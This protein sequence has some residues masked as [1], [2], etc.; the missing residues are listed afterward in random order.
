MEKQIQPSEQKIQDL[1]AALEVRP[2]D[3]Q[4]FDSL[5]SLYTE[6]A[7]W[8][9]LL[10][11]Y[12]R[13]ARRITDGPA[14]AEVYYEMGKVW[15]ERVGN[16]QQAMRH[17]QLAYRA[18]PTYT[19]ALSAAR[20]IYRDLGNW[21][22]VSRLLEIQI[23]VEEDPRVRADLLCGLGQALQNE[24]GDARRA[25]EC[26]EKALE[27]VP[28]HPIARDAL[29]A[30]TASREKWREVADRMRDEAE[31]ATEPA[32]RAS[33]Y[34]RIAELYHREDRGA[35][36]V[37]SY[38]RRALE[39]D[40]ANARAA[41]ILAQVLEEQGRLDELGRFLAGRAAAAQSSSERA[42]I[43]SRLAQLAQTTGN[44]EAALA[45]WREVLEIDPQNAEA[46]MAL[47]A[48]LRRR[49]AHPE[50]FE[51]ADRAL[52]TGLSQDL[53]A[54]LLREVGEVAWRE[55]GDRPRAERYLGSLRRIAPSDPLCLEFFR[56]EMTEGQDW[57]GQY[58][59]LARSVRYEPDVS[60]RREIYRTMARMAEERLGNAKDAIDAWRSVLD[61]DRGDSEA[62]E[63][64]K[65]LYRRA[66]RWH[67]LVELLKGESEQL[68]PER[69]EEKIALYEEMADIYGRRLQMEPMVVNTL[70]A[71]LQ[72]APTHR[73]TLDRLAAIYERR[74]SW[75]QLAE[76]LT[77][78]AS[79]VD[80]PSD[81]L[82]L[83]HR[84]AEIWLSR[85]QSPEDA[86]RRYEE[87][88]ALNP[89]DVKALQSLRKI[90]EQRRA[91]EPLVQIYLREID[92]IAD[93]GARVRR[94]REVAEWA[95]KHLHRPARLIELWNKVLEF[96]DRD[97]RAL[98]ALAVLY[99]REERW[100][101]LAE[102]L[103]RQIQQTEDAR[104]RVPLMKRLGQLW[105]ERLGREDHALALW[106]EALALD[107]DNL[108]VFKILRDR[109]LKSRDYAA[110]E[111]LYARR[112]KWEE[113]VD[114]L[115]V[116]A[117][118]HPDPAQKCNIYFQIADVW[119]TRLARKDRS[120]RVYE[121][122]LELDP[123]NVRA[124]E[125]LRTGYEAT[126]EWRKLA[127]VE[128]VLAEATPDPRERAD[129]L[130][131]IGQIYEE[132]LRRTD[133]AFTHAARAF[134]DAPSGAEAIAHLERLAEALG[135]WK[136]LAATF[137]EARQRTEDPALRLDLGLRTAR[138]QDQKLG[139]LEEALAAWEAVRAD[140][141][142]HVEALEALARLYRK[143]ERWEK[144]LELL[145]AELAA[146]EEPAR[147]RELLYEIAVLEEERLDRPDEAIEVYKAI[148]LVTDDDPQALS[149][150]ARLYEATERHEPLA[151]VLAR[152]LDRARGEVE[153]VPLLYRLGR[154]LMGPLGDPS[155]AVERFRRL[156]EI[157]PGHDGA[158]GALE[159][160][161]RDSP[162]RDAAA[163]LLAQVHRAQGAWARALDAYE[164]LVRAAAPGPE[165]VDLLLEM[166]RICEQE[167]HSV[168]EA[169]G[170]YARA[171]H[172]DPADPRTFAELD[173]VA[174]LLDRD[175]ALARLLASELKRIDNTGYRAQLTL[176]AAILHEE[177][178]QAA[179]A[180]RYY[181]EALA[182]GLPDEGA[183]RALRSLAQLH[184]SRQD[185]ASLLATLRRSLDFA[186]SSAQRR[187]ILVR[188]GELL[189]GPLG[190]APRAI[191]AYRNALALDPE[192]EEVLARLAALYEAGGDW[193]RLAD[194]L[195]SQIRLSRAAAE[196][197]QLHCRLG[198]LFANRLD[199]PSDA[200]LEL[201]AALDAD[202]DCAAAVDAIEA[203]VERD[204]DLRI[205]AAETLAP[206]YESRGDMEKVSLALEA[207]LPAR[208]PAERVEILHRLAAIA[209]EAGKLERAFEANLR[210]LR[211]MPADRET[212]VRLGRLADALRR[213]PDLLETLEAEL[214]RIEDPA[215]RAAAL[216]DMASAAEERL[217]D[218]E[219]SAGY[220]E[221][222][223]EI[224]PESTAALDGLEELYPRVQRWRELADLLDRRLSAASDPLTAREI[225]VRL[226]QILE[227]QLQD[228]ARAID[229][230]RKASELF[231]EDLELLDALERLHLATGQHEELAGVYLKRADLAASAEQ[232]K[233]Y[234]FAAAAL[235]EEKLRHPE[236]AVQIYRRVADADPRDLVALR[237][238]VRLYEELG[239]AESLL[240]SLTLLVEAIPEG[241]DRLSLR[242]RIGTLWE[243]PLASPEQAVEIY[244]DLLADEPEH[245]PTIASLEAMLETPSRL[246]A[247]RVLGPLYA[248]HGEW[249]KLV[250]ALEV[251]LSEVEDAEEKVAILGR[252]AEVRERRL[253]D[254]EGAF[255]AHRQALRLSPQTETTITELERIASEHDRYFELAAAYEEILPDLA[256]PVLARR[257]SLKV[258]RI[259]DDIL[260][261]APRAVEKYK[262]VL[263][264]APEE[265]SALQALERLHGE[266]R[267]WP[268]LAHTLRRELELAR[269]PQEQVEL[270]HRL[271]SLFAGALA[272]PVQAVQSFASA[273]EGDPDHAGTLRALESMLA[274]GTEVPAVAALL[275]PVY[276]RHGAWEKLARLLEVEADAIPAPSERKRVY[277][278]IAEIH[279]ERLHNLD[280]AFAFLARAMREDPA[281]TETMRELWRLSDITGAWE[282]LAALLD[283]EQEREELGDEVRERLALQVAAIYEQHLK[284]PAAAAERYQSVVERNPRCTAALRQLDR[285][286]TTAE[287][288]EPLARVLRLEA[289]AAHGSEEVG[290]LARLA[291]LYETRLGDLD[292]AVAISRQILEKD[293]RNLTALEALER[294]FRERDEPEELFRVYERRA[295]LCAE[296]TERA[297]FFAAM[298][299]LA[300]TR[301]GRT[302][303]A[304]ELWHR[305]LGAAGEDD[306]ALAA[307]ER[308]YEETERFGELCEVLSRRA[309]IATDLDSRAA[310]LRRRGEVYAEKLERAEEAIESFRSVLQARPG[311]LVALEALRQLYRRG[312]RFGELCD[313]LETTVAVALREAVE[314]SRLVDLYAELGEVQGEVLMRPAAAIDAWNR[315]LELEP[316]HRLALEKLDQLYADQEAWHECAEIVERRIATASDEEDRV[317]AMRHLA[318]IYDRQM[319]QPERAAEVYERLLEAR[320]GEPEAARALESLHERLGNFERLTEL[321]LA[322][323]ETMDVPYERLELL[324]R[325]AE[326]YLDRL[327][328]SDLA[329]IVLCRALQE[330]PRDLDLLGE[331][332]RLARKT[333]NFEELALVL[334]D[335][336]GKVTDRE[337]LISLHG[338]VARYYSE[339]LG[340]ADYAVAHYRRILVLDEANAETLQALETLLRREGR[341]QELAE[342]LRRKAEL[343]VDLRE[344][345]EFL[346]DLATLCEQSLG[347]LGAAA[348]A[349]QDIVH[350][351][352]RDDVAL[353]ALRRIYRQEGRWRDLIDVLKRKIEL[354]DEREEA[355]VLR[356]Q[357]ASIY[358]RDLGDPD[359]AAE[360]YREVLAMDPARHDARENLERIFTL[361]RRWDELVAL[362]G[363][364]IS[365][366]HGPGEEVALHEKIAA[367]WEEQLGHPE[368]AIDSYRAILRVDPKHDM[369]LESLERLYGLKQRWRDLAE[370]LERRVFAARTPEES[371]RHLRRLGEVYE[372]RLADH[373]QAQS[374]YQR[375]LEANPDDADAL[376]AL[377]GIYEAAGDYR[378]CA[379]TL[380][381]AARVDRDRRRKAET[382]HRVAVLSRERL[383]D[384][385][386]AEAA[387]RF[388][389]EADPTYLPALTALGDLYG[390]R[391]DWKQA[392]NLLQR[393]EE[394]STDVQHKADLLA[395]MGR[396]AADELRDPVVAARYYEMALEKVPSFLPAARPLADLYFE[397]GEPEKARALLEMV[398]QRAAEGGLDPRDL[399]LYR[400]RLAVVTEKAGDEEAAL[401]YYQ[402]AYEADLTYLPTLVALGD[403]LFRRQDWERAFKVYQSLV[404]HHSDTREVDLVEIYHR[405][406]VVREKLGERRKAVHSFDKALEMNPAHV[407][408]LKAL[409]RLHEEAGE[410]EEAVSVRKR[411]VEALTDPV[412]K[413]E[414]AIAVSDTYREKLKSPPRAI[415]ALVDA[416]DF[417]PRNLVLLHKLL[418]LYTETKQWR[419]AVDVL[420]EITAIE[421]DPGKLSTY[422]YSIAVI[423]RDEIKETDRAIEYFNRTLDAS[424]M[425]LKAFEA[426][427]KILTQRKD[428]TALAQNYRTMIGRLG[429]GAPVELQAMLWKNLGE[430]YRTRLRNFP[431]AIPC[432]QKA[433]ALTPGDATLHVILSELYE[434][435]PATLEEAAREHRALLASEPR[436]HASY[437]ALYRIYREAKEHDRAYR[438]CHTLR[439][440]GE[441][442]PHEAQYL[443]QLR[444]RAPKRPQRALDERLWQILLHPAE[445]RILGRVF[446][447]LTPAVAQIYL[448][449][450]KDLGVRRKD[451]IDTGNLEIFFSRIFQLCRGVLGVAPPEVYLKPEGHMGL[452]LMNTAP[453]TMLVGPDMVQDRPEPELA[454]AIAKNLSY[455]RPEHF[456]CALLPPL[457]DTI[458]YAGVKACFP[459]QKLPEDVDRKEIDELQKRIEKAIPPAGLATLRTLLQQYYQMARRFDAAAW[460]AS[461]EQTGD[462]AGFLL[463]N[464]LASAEKV[465]QQEPV[466]ISKLTRAD[467]V[468]DLILF[469]VSE[470]Y[471]ELRRGLAMA[472]QVS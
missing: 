242:H 69:L 161:M 26:Y 467:K 270:H 204:P 352:E 31:G 381:R 469:S 444:P 296:E 50:L 86:I 333:G 206:V 439:Y 167:L 323:L 100:A 241:P 391:G 67:A 430:I 291:D 141:P 55:L 235:Y 458:F 379:D 413:V 317:A 325:I 57:K 185:V 18:H 14:R 60:K 316:T 103:Q 393:E 111:Q 267:D 105:A 399:A 327:N 437:H 385:A 304:I 322:R 194:I 380:E 297:P 405:L 186:E 82:E 230:Y 412:E 56:Q 158:I 102:V 129:R 396:I 398:V 166:A 257:L 301:L 436:R 315:V 157:E 178:S 40:A 19:R 130:R 276:R 378:S 362:L 368:R 374:A 21:K 65:G 127:Q 447:F 298:A 455:L 198:D 53:Q 418:E 326:V 95:Q 431:E 58:D 90:Y 402:A 207:I 337:L 163:K 308:L 155:A 461:I 48:L 182:L 42:P 314:V 124:A 1:L 255:A 151:D 236:R 309:E 271:G 3:R 196:K 29:G 229:A 219:R 49:R 446:A 30:L 389:M 239:D 468:K 92:L 452:T 471:F 281:D 299:E 354:A 145:R 121:R 408:T 421:T 233:Q 125:A 401:R 62:R 451:Q 295:E 120:A 397:R 136:D 382:W 355:L 246:L 101:S 213:W 20:R 373:A 290:F 328:R 466:A 332:E 440:L 85:L 192:D 174:T 353:E 403:L 275:E 369:A 306:Q 12:E 268:E 35:P 456:L 366:A 159:E 420:G 390:S 119:E 211:E 365:F 193:T 307:L 24:L 454:F 441:I 205:L 247:A 256:E 72:A 135:A 376:A 114:V 181:D 43:L 109:H 89:T 386:R 93:A 97:G 131:R 215:E 140:V 252:I 4:A 32:L 81:K 66:E 169:L 232:R 122:I 227:R 286:Y 183:R 415:D 87:I 128:E 263:A 392:L 202:P 258:A 63:R 339:E 377:G 442:E 313:V 465:L 64:L 190:E 318:E 357:I 262:R 153:Q 175:E 142:D 470:E 144:L 22:M 195:A 180:I 200:L 450:P 132:K 79:A 272:D 423:Y 41:E 464:D 152:L 99:E 27:L 171:F 305:V 372:D 106:E 346:F 108:D 335:L 216:C 411:L 417:S 361:Q 94:A 426:V 134:R 61:L 77:K 358:D 104:A 282:E 321:L 462:R 472:V 344:K 156:L 265:R 384:V 243:G 113:Y 370:V 78:K 253:G 36:E 463:C 110:L 148:L 424:P 288:W 404:V 54:R 425:R 360:V 221:R 51:L 225:A 5:R 371:S 406:G 59:L 96:D 351:D 52:K 238:L 214:G 329:F 245:A 394:L 278:E 356:L 302:E 137:E 448:V 226:G 435:N 220:Y 223:L 350:L 341:L 149:A 287:A 17:Y 9:A 259:Y 445:D 126:G 274:A 165:R 395:Q 330:D 453:V 37:E 416:L 280:L 187:K 409:I 160:L 284:Q 76:V 410:W 98:Q 387:L 414:A 438:I 10:K 432:F 294:I 400:H 334:E 177:S 338:T 118:S 292:F 340:R 383:G 348:R 210:A 80:D 123:R 443:E 324:R 197:A 184:E 138:I 208:P 293:P 427:D 367:L 285:L 319:H 84:A 250:R 172:E 459:T 449:H 83:L 349:L 320:P 212:R 336:I 168:E 311:D 218:L 70:T 375:I 25:V 143:A 277:R 422:Y 139:R 222:V 244:R 254:A 147:K 269:D 264:Y 73:P 6:L 199:R 68:P 117:E 173:R 343:A 189:E 23:G 217:G 342:I 345:K 429:D 44:D 248:R 15:D 115:V 460:L 28:D 39:I 289:D 88:L 300:A 71:I 407:P 266:L 237:A 2:D 364:Q 8:D 279:E 150:L 234:L 363:E 251:E 33:L 434:E 209:E 283:E 261:D 7:R 388:A 428:W 231:P 331:V 162:A 146:V 188:M 310:L 74:E 16:K 34:V 154:L 312:R 170:L 176:R 47:A 179:E 45:R 75:G 228:P 249:K 203:L 303:D 224:D 201:R 11:L 116:Q 91:Y 13:E 457:V 419:R 133:L 107:P 433:S 359:R 347:D 260:H 191:E 164:V 38:A 112:G 273:L 46:L 240:G